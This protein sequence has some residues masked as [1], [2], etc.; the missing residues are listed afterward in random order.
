MTDPSSDPV[1]A[2]IE[3]ALG[4]I[5]GAPVVVRSA[6]YAVAYDQFGGDAGSNGVAKACVGNPLE[7]GTLHRIL[8]TMIYESLEE[9]YEPHEEEPGT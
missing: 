5:L 7:F 3:A 2:A 9:L 8:D 4:E 1:R 6:V